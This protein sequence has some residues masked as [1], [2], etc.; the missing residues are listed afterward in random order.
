MGEYLDYIAVSF[1]DSATT[2]AIGTALG[3]PFVADRIMFYSTEDCYVT[4][5]GSSLQIYI[6][7]GNFFEFEKGTKSLSIIRVTSSGTLH[8]WAEGNKLA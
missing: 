7:K 2:Y 1:T 3:T 6:P 4:Y 8:V 5:H